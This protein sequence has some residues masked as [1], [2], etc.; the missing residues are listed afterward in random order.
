ME[1]ELYLST[2]SGICCCTLSGEIKKHTLLEG[3]G[4]LCATPNHLLCA[5]MREI[6]R[7]DRR[8]LMPQSVYPGGP[9]ICD[10]CL[11]LEEQRI[12]A[13]CSEADS[14]VMLDAQNGQPLMLGRAG[15]APKQM[16]LS[17][18]TL[19]VAGGEN[20]CVHQLSAH[21]LETENIWFMARSVYGVAAAHD[22]VYALCLTETLNSLLVTIG[23]GG[24][25]HALPLSGM[26][27]CL[28]PHRNVLLAATQQRLYAISRDGTQILRQLAAPGRA[29]RMLDTGER[30]LLH[31][32]LDECLFSGAYPYGPWTVLH[33]DIQYMALGKACGA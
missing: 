8:T 24:K 1:E 11:S 2:K 22:A 27:G 21:T 30:L 9:G 32:P 20:G 10:L 14:V 28:L 29:C 26:P 18:Q 23:P 19:I 17:G 13:L 33:Q 7:L 4:A 12:F 25:R 3:A 16:I 5:C 15:C 6:Y 31:D